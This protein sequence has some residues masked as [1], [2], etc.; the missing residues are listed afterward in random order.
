MP[1]VVEVN[2]A[3]PT[4][5]VLVGDGRD[6][7]EADAVTRS[8]MVG[9]D[10]TVDEAHALLLPPLAVGDVTGLRVAVLEAQKVLEE[11]GEGEMEGDCDTDALRERDI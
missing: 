5:P 1:L 9:I 10:V 2:V 8:V 11:E 4:L 6:V 7:T 3:F